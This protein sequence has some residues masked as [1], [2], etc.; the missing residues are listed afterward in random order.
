MTYG[1][2]LHNVV[3]SAI[4]TIHPDELCTLYRANGQINNRGLITPIYEE[5]EQ[6]KVN[7]QPL[8]ANTLQHLEQVG[9]TQASEQIFAYS[10]QRKTIAGTARKPIMRGGDFIQRYDKTYWLVTSV[11]EDWS[12]DGWINAGITRQI[13]PPDFSAST[14]YRA[15]DKNAGCCK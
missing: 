7:F 6:V 5:P 2:N 12:Q 11:I 4:T 13:T 10:M 1:L 14:W 15:G 3:R 8:D 9:D